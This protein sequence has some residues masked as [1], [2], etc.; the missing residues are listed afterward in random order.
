MFSGVKKAFNQEWQDTESKIDSVTSINGFLL[1]FKRTL[2][3]YGVQNNLFYAERFERLR[4][5][6]YRTTEEN[7]G[8]PFASSQYSMMAD[9][10][11]E[12]CF[13]EVKK[14]EDAR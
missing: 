2:P 3:I 7:E 4:I 8:F 11:I 6:F 1:A 5:S 14:E 12:D 10:I 13:P 9:R